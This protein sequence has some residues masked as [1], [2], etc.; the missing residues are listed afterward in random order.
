MIWRHVLI[1]FYKGK[2]PW[3]GLK[4]GPKQQKYE[5]IRQKKEAISVED[6]CSDMP[7]MSLILITVEK[8]ELFLSLSFFKTFQ[9]GFMTRIQSRFNK[10]HLTKLYS[11]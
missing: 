2:L 10:T 8:K 6:L 4:I 11:H 9:N 1:Y 5:L 3:Q 7:S